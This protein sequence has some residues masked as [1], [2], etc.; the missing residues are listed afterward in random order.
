M[1][2]DKFTN[3]LKE[4]GLKFNAGAFQASLSL[5]IYMGFEHI[6]FVGVSLH[7]QSLSNRWYQSGIGVPLKEYG[8]LAWRKNFFSIALKYVDDINI[9]TYI[10]S[11]S[12]YLDTITYQ[13]LTGLSPKYRDTNQILDPFMQRMMDRLGP[14]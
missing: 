14:F 13:N 7:E 9:V 5:A 8:D 3:E 12:V 4:N 2:G 11:K 1:P 6:F 10:N